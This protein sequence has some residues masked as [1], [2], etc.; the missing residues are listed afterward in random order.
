MLRI[1]IMVFAVFS[2]SLIFPDTFEERLQKYSRLSV[3]YEML[4]KQLLGPAGM[5][6]EFRKFKARNPEYYRD[7]YTRSMTAEYVCALLSDKPKY[8]TAFRQCGLSKGGEFLCRSRECAV[9]GAANQAGTKIP[10]RVELT[11]NNV[12]LLF[13][14]CTGGILLFVFVTAFGRYVLGWF[15]RKFPGKQQEGAEQ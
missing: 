3:Q 14:S 4:E 6:P 10:A 7:S 13:V 11:R 12:F 1:S 8:L 9:H 15:D 5:R 2:A